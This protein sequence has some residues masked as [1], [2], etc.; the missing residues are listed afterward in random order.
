MKLYV[1]SVPA[2]FPAGVPRVACQPVLPASAHGLT[3]K[4][5]H[6]A[7]GTLN[8]YMRFITVLAWAAATV[9]NQHLYIRTASRLT[10]IGTPL[11]PPP[12]PPPAPAAK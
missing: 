4:P 7:K 5:W 10:C 2:A 12:P 11:A 9:A 3:S 8:T 6:P 1:F